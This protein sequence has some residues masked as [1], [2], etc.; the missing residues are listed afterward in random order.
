MKMQ[1]KAC[2]GKAGNKSCKAC[3]GAGYVHKMTMDEDYDNMKKASEILKGLRDLDISEDDAQRIVKGKIEA[4]KA[5]DDL[6]TAAL[7]VD[8]L[9]M[10]VK[11]M[12]ASLAGDYSP[13]DPGAALVAK[14]G[15]ELSD[16]IEYGEGSVELGQALQA[17]ASADS[18]V[19]K[20]LNTLAYEA[21]ANHEVIG[22]GMLA[23]AK[24]MRD[25]ASVFKA[26]AEAINS[27]QSRQDQIAKAMA[28][29][30]PPKSVLTGAT[31]IAAP[32]E[33]EVAK[34]GV[35]PKAADVSDQTTAFDIK[36]AAEFEM[37]EIRKGGSVLDIN[38]KQRMGELASAI[39]RC[40]SGGIPAD[41]IARQFNIK[42]A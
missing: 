7:N 25:Q 24:L 14:G 37:N 22:K 6:D 16:M 11:A 23:M 10:A 13:E 8:E 40:E 26:Q 3:G 41:D 17:I 31:A 9:D 1:C 34:G 2:K 28:L 27:I 33:G 4:G 38:Q 29:P 15:E 32:H 12:T 19:A 20:G 30:V 18:N 36:K 39:A 21:R 5:F 35:D 42:V